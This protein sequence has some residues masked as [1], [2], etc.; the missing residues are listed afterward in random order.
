M[1]KGGWL[2]IVTRID[3]DAAVV[4]VADTGSGIPAE[5]LS[6]IYDPF[7]TTKAI[8]KGTGLGL[9]ITY[10]IVQEHGGTITC[11]SDVGQGTRFTLRLPLAV[12][13]APAHQARPAGRV[14]G[15]P[16]R[17]SETRPASL[18]AEGYEQFH[19]GHRR[20]GDHA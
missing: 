12:P 8:G 2:T 18:P 14:A 9:S 1:P 7:F 4:E 20:R 13:A 11:D 10:G 19:S 3:A 5:Q 15:P 6:R 16:P 17:R